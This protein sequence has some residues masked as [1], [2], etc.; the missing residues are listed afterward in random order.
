MPFA[1]SFD[2]FAC[3]GDTITC[4]ADGF[5]VTAR[6]EFDA[7]S[8]IDDDDCHNE[9]Q[10]VTG[11]N[12]EQFAKL[13]EARKAWLNDEWHYCGVVLSVSRAGVLLDDHA[14]SLWGIELNY[15][16]GDNSYLTETANELLDEALDEARKTLSDLL[17]TVPE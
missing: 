7:D 1:E 2:K 9:D 5:D 8:H 11:C 16:G 12:D 14:A 17:A 3:I 15:P 4:T 13:L 10:A 6:L